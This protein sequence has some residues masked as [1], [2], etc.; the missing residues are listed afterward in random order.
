MKSSGGR[1]RPIAAL[2]AVLA[3]VAGSVAATAG[4]GAL[5]VQGVAV[6]GPT[7]VVTV[8]NTGDET[9]TGSVS[10]TVKMKDRIVKLSQPVTVPEGQKAYLPVNLPMPPDDVIAAGVILD[11]GS[12]F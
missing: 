3:V 2:V 6:A 1:S 11:D 5:Q 7:V 10:V 4:E 8:V 12:P 9:M